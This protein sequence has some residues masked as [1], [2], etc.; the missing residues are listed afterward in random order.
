MPLAFTELYAFVHSVNDSSQ[1]AIGG[2]EIFIDSNGYICQSQWNSAGTRGIANL[3][4]TWI[5]IGKLA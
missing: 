3:P 2:G 1:T 5:A 4:V